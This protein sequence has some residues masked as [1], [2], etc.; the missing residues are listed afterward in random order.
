MEPVFDN[1][2]GV[3]ETI[4]GDMGGSK[5][6]ANYQD[7][8]TGRTAHIETV[9]VTYNKTE[10]DYLTSLHALWRSIDP[11]DMDGQFADKGPQYRTAIFVSLV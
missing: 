3:T 9:E 2:P 10:V 5:E 1:I 4:S 8:S 6:T 11:T 7:V